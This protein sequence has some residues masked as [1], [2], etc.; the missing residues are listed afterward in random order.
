M[1]E[2]CGE[3]H[4]RVKEISKVKIIASLFGETVSIEKERIR[5][6]EREIESERKKKAIRD[7]ILRYDKERKVE[8]MTSDNKHKSLTENRQLINKT[9]KGKE[10]DERKKSWDTAHE[11]RKENFEKLRL[12]FEN[13]GT[14]TGSLNLKINSQTDKQTT[15]L[16]YRGSCKKIQLGRGTCQTEE[17][18]ILNTSNAIYLTKQGGE[19]KGELNPLKKCTVSADKN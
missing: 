18:S 9:V 5:Q 13:G 15:I 7:K 17:K 1:Q 16:T 3:G 14:K 12:N 6:K 10:K 4:G 19:S 2:R 11:E 8:K